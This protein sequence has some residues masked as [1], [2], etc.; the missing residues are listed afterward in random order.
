LGWAFFTADLLGCYRRCGR[1]SRRPAAAAEKR[2]DRQHQKH[3]EQ[4]PGNL[5]GGAGDSGEAEYAGDQRDHQ[6]NKGIVQHGQSFESGG[7]SILQQRSL[8]SGAGFAAS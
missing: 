3:H 4:N 5:A 7:D 6:E 2:N 8:A 1:S